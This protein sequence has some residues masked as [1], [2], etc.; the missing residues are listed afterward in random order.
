MLGHEG[1]EATCERIARKSLASP[2]SGGLQEGRLLVHGCTCM[3]KAL[4]NN[5]ALQAADLLDNVAKNVRLLAT[6]ST[7][8][9]NTDSITQ[10]AEGGQWV[11]MVD[12]FWRTL[13]FGTGG[14]RG[15]TIGRVITAAEQGKAKPGARP[16]SPC[17]GTNAM[18]YFNISRAAQWRTAMN[19]SKRR[20]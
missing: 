10:L 6:S 5:A 20:S 14:L 2:A 19:T 1:A 9:V 13:A 17:V 15:R 16:E 8:P 7:S 11:E 4:A 18:N 3:K 12:R